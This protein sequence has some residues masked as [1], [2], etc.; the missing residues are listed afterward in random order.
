MSNVETTCCFTGNR[1]EKLPWGDD[2]TDPAFSAFYAALESTLETLYG[3]GYRAFIGGMARGGDTWFAEAVLA[4][5]GKHP[6]V[7]FEAA[8][9]FPE[10]AKGWNAVS[11]ARYQ[12]I[13]DKSDRVTTVCP[14]Y[15]RYCMSARNRYM[16]DRSSVV[17]SLLRSTG[18]TE[19]TV[20][21]AVKRGVRVIAL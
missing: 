15:T 1:P 3:E 9:P 21:Y 14:C 20:A 8:V 13:L 18:G 10:Q 16:V 12:A 7:T 11:R 19:K 17:I 2:E 6:D 4:L 5:K